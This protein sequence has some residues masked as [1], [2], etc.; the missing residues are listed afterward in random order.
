MKI[1]KVTIISGVVAG[2]VT[3]FVAKK[4]WKLAIVGA[5]VGGVAGYYINQRMNKANVP[6]PVTT[7]S[8]EMDEEQSSFDQ[9]VEPRFQWNPTINKMMPV[10]QINEVD[11]DRVYDINADGLDLDFE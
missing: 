4:N 6:A 5:L 9:S 3:Y 11:S 1:D 8:D 10:G 2:G 7:K